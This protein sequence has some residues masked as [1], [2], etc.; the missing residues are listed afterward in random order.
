MTLPLWGRTGLVGRRKT[1]K[2]VGFEVMRWWK[3]KVQELKRGVLVLQGR[4]AI[5]KK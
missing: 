1:G 2:V 5:A 4:Q 3:R